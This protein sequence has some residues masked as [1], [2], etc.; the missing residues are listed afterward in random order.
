MLNMAKKSK[1]MQMMDTYAEPEIEVG[2]TKPSNS[3]VYAATIGSILLSLFLL[4]RNQRLANFT[5]LWAPT[6]LSLGVMMKAN[7]MIDLEKRMLAYR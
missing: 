3:L 2:A 7:K 1:P 4:P 5:G 6:I